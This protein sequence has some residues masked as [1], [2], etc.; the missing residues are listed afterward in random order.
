MNPLRHSGSRWVRWTS[1]SLVPVTRPP[2][3]QLTTGGGQRSVASA[4]HADALPCDE[5]HPGGP[6]G[7]CGQRAE[8]SQR[9]EAFLF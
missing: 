6:R 9:N 8:V 7:R 1:L 4:Q 3:G 2:P 5:S